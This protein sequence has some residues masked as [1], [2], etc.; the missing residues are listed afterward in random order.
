MYYRKHFSK[1]GVVCVLFLSSSYIAIICFVQMFFDVAAWN[2]MKEQ[3][4]IKSAPE[5]KHKY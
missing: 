2:K 5:Q 3:K 1:I 4:W